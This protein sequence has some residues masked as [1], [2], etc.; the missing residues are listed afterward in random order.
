MK[1]SNTHLRTK[2]FVLIFFGL[3]SIGLIGVTGCSSNSNPENGGN[4]GGK[5]N[6]NFD[7]GEIV[8]GKSFSYTFK[9]EGTFPYYCT[10]HY[11]SGMTGTI[12]VKKGAK[13]SGTVTIKMTNDLKFD[14]ATIT[15]A[16]DT[17]VTWDNTSSM[18]HTATSGNPPSSGGGGGY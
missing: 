8:P 1:N 3:L 4:G 7:S 10:Y 15:I 5:S 11:A 17:K 18:H 6:A 9:K 13:N 12:T 14:P 2:T 16:P